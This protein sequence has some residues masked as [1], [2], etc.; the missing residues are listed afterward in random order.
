MPKAF[1]PGAVFAAA[2]RSAFIPPRGIAELA[3]ASGVQPL[4]SAIAQRAASDAAVDEALKLRGDFGWSQIYDIIEF[5]GG[6]DRIATA[7]W[8]SKKRTSEVRQTANHFR[9]L[10]SPK[11]SRL[12]ARPP[13]I[14]QARVFAGDLLKR[15]IASRL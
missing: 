6:A 15:W 10:G 7:G 8:T 1:R 9:H 3:D 14:D 2:A 11:Q 12:P 5:L 4:G 13:T